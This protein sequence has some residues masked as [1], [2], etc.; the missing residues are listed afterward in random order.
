ML[1]LEMQQQ[2]VVCDCTYC[3]SFIHMVTYWDRHG[4]D[5]VQQAAVIGIIKTTTTAEES[6]PLLD[7]KK[8]GKRKSKD[9]FA[10][11]HH[12][13]GRRRRHDKDY[14]LKRF[15]IG[16]WLLIILIGLYHRYFGD[17]SSQNVRKMLE[18][19][20]DI[21]I[22]GV[23]TAV[24]HTIR[25]ASDT[26]GWMDGMSLGEWYDS[27]VPRVHARYKNLYVAHNI[28]VTEL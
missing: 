21:S 10:C 25:H 5:K 18:K 3:S 19:Y 1:S 14:W 24:E 15:L 6:A 26:T 8:S 7:K 9:K 28:S 16:I 22:P 13:C 12:Y 27:H 20:D 11:L 2:H 17:H 23:P 4:K